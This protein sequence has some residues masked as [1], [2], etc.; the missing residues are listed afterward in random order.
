[1]QLRGVA[2]RAD[3]LPPIVHPFAQLHE[4]ELCLNPAVELVIQR[5]AIRLPCHV[6]ARVLFAQRAPLVRWIL[7]EHVMVQGIGRLAG[8]EVTVEVVG[9][10]PSHKLASDD[11]A[12]REKEMKKTKKKIIVSSW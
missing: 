6:V 12:K 4:L 3:L 9:L 10:L 11:G 2:L 7:R 8:T 5:L 1:M